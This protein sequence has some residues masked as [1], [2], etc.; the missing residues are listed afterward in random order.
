MKHLFRFLFNSRSLGLLTLAL[1]LPLSFNPADAGKPDCIED[2]THPSCKDDGGGNELGPYNLARASFNNFGGSGDGGIS[3]DGWDTCTI[4][5]DGDPETTYDLVTYDYWAWEER[6]LMDTGESIHDWDESCIPTLDIAS[7]GTCCSHDN[8][9]DVSG[10]GRWKLSTTA[11]PDADWVVARWLDVDFSG[12]HPE[13][14]PDPSDC[15][16][17]DSIYTAGQHPAPNLNDCVASLNVWF[18][19]RFILKNNADFGGG[20]MTIAHWPDQAAPDVDGW[21]PW[22]TISYID[23]PLYLRDPHDNG[24]FGGRDCRVMSTRPAYNANHDRAVAELYKKHG[25]GNPETNEYIG[26]YYLPW[27]VCVIRASDSN[28]WLKE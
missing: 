24:P 1:F 17:L 10:G 21:H 16:D 5:G 27:E 7:G 20:G 18:G 13:I 15:P 2:P 25:T 9:S 4:D 26:T 22:G 3:A 6:L 12:S 19:N 23:A 11:G 8:R 14:L 28:A